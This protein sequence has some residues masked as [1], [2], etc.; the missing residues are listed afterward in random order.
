MKTVAIVTIYDSNPN[1]GNKLQ[2]YASVQIL[3][4]LGCAVSTI[5]T[6]P[7]PPVILIRIKKMPN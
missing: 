3:K 4:E 2:N 1:Y 7:Q 5:I 6:E